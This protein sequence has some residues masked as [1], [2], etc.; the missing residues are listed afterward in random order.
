MKLNPPISHNHLFEI[1]Y[2][3]YHDKKVEVYNNLSD[4]FVDYILY[5]ANKL[6]MRFVLF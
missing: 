5:D 1:P 3:V 2:I 6:N 4:D